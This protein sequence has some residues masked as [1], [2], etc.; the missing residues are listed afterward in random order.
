MCLKLNVLYFF[1]SKCVSRAR[2][3]PNISSYTSPSMRLPGMEAKRNRET[4]ITVTLAA[5]SELPALNC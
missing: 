1:I 2:A 3:S 5:M 4:A